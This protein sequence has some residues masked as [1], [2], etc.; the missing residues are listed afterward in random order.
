MQDAEG[1][2]LLGRPHETRAESM[3]LARRSTDGHWRKML[4]DYDAANRTEEFVREQIDGVDRFAGL[5][6]RARV[7]DIGC[8]AGAQTLE[9][10][11]RGCR[12]LGLDPDSSSL[13][14]ARALS[15]DKGLWVH[16]QNCD[17]RRIPY[18]GEFNVAVNLHT[19]LGNLPREL[20]DLRCLQA[21][22]KA[23]KPDGKFLLDLPNRDWLVRN[24]DPGA[25]SQKVF[26][27]ETG[28]LSQGE[29]SVR[30][31]S[32]TELSRLLGLAGFAMRGAWG[33]YDGAPFTLS[34]L[35]MIVL[36]A[37]I[38]AEKAP[39]RVD[40]LPRAIRIKGRG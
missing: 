18:D 30:V 29:R 5:K 40:D 22:H 38:P 31:Y 39:R 26:D 20:D 10:A 7:L 27:L 24:L 3:G 1:T 11:R 19:P 17:L 34:S 6:E 36:A 23:L 35:R 28:L 32:L 4:A 14:R 15:Q 13:A 9:I 37:K 25:L 33:G 2:I 12:V 8:G 16:F 21:V